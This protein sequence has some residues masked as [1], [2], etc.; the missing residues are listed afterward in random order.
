MSDAEKTSRIVDDEQ[1]EQVSGGLGLNPKEFLYETYITREGSYL[2][3]EPDINAENLAVMR[4]YTKIG[5]VD[6][7]PVG[8]IVAGGATI[9]NG[10]VKCYARLDSYVALGYACVDHLSPERTYRN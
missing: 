4:L 3:K 5:V 2:K 6:D 7:T 8:S 1:L 10:Y 9:F